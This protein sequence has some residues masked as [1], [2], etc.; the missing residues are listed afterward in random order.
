MTQRGR[1]SAASIVTATPA[2]VAAE[3]RLAAPLHLSD[4]ERAVWMEVVNDQPASAFTAT[5]APLLEMY[6]RHVTNARVLAEEILNFERA[7][8]ADDDGLKRYDRL[9][10]MSERESRAASSLATRLRITRQAVEHP[11][12][13]GRSLTNQKKARKP[14]ELP[15]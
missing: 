14:W 5:H 12:T 3:Q 2:P 9:L 1:K 6:C 15:A 8:L 13:V 7:W 10:A 11:T 4:G